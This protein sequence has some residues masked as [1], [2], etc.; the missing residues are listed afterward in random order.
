MSRYLQEVANRLVSCDTVSTKSN[1]EATEYLG[2]HLDRHGFRVAYHRTDIAGVAKVNLVACAGP[3]E[4]DG[5]II[6]GHI[7]VVPLWDN[8]D[9]NVTRST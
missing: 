6:S 7:D 3:P 8:Q 1:A 2:E 9:G 4:P 5:L